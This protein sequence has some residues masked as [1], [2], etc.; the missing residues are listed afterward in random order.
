MISGLESVALASDVIQNNNNGIPHKGLNRIK[1]L[2]A[3][4]NLKKLRGLDVSYNRLVSLPDFTKNPKLNRIFNI[5][6][7]NL[8]PEEIQ[9]KIPK[10][11]VDDIEALLAVQNESKTYTECCDSPYVKRI[12]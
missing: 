9:A 3:L 10:N 6:F 1:N 7:N 11:L 4:K 12:Y 2:K 8:S 5:A